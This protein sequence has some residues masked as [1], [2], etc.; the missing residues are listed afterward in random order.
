MEI[1]KREDQSD[2]NKMAMDVV[3]LW[4]MHYGI[5]YPEAIK[6]LRSHLQQMVRDKSYFAPR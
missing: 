1:F 6:M 2:P 3:H 4:A 5:S